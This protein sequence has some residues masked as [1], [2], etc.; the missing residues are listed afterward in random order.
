MH[1]TIWFVTLYQF[2][3]GKKRMFFFLFPLVC[4]INHDKVIRFLFYIY[5]QSVWCVFNVPIANME[6]CVNRLFFAFTLQ[7]ARTLLALGALFVSG[8]DAL[9]L[10]WPI[11]IQYSRLSPFF[12]FLFM[13]FC[14]IFNAALLIA[15][16]ANLQSSSMSTSPYI[17]QC[18]KRMIYSRERFPLS[19][20][21][22]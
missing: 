11:L 5:F 15:W 16:T 3:A 4:C 2:R 19:P 9:P 22:S 18:M 21:V 7:A 13:L 14:V 17:I 12:F 10:S 6:A 8:D 1:F 20:A